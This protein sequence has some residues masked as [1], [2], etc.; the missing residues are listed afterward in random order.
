M[1]ECLRP[2][3]IVE[4]TE[5]IFD[6]LLSDT[7]PRVLHLCDQQAELLDRLSPDAHMLLRCVLERIEGEHY[8]YL[9]TTHAE[10]DRILH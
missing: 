8:G 7:L 1:S 9:A 4:H 5:Q 10:F 3:V 2:F 6:N